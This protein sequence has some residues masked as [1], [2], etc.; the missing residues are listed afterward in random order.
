MSSVANLISTDEYLNSSYE[1][2]RELVDGVLVDR[3][4]GSQN[5]ADLQGL[6][7]MFLGQFRKSHRIKVLP[8]ARLRVKTSGAY[9]I[10]D[11]LVLERPYKRGKV[12]EDVPAVV[13]EINSPDDRFD[14]VV[15]K[16]FE[17]ESLG[18]G[19]ILVMDPDQ[20]RAWRFEHGTMKLLA[21]GTVGL[22]LGRQQ[23]T[24]DFPFEQL[25]A[26]L[27]ED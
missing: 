16:C 22:R 24:V 17:Y 18:V 21:G 14:Q 3:N 20:R 13:I 26:E 23:A 6:L 4:V 2:D 7:T 12:V 27:E 10:P 5:H 11:L 19:N 9:R 15:D 8:E 1:P 25:F